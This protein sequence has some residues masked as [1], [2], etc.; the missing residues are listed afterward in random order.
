M[1]YPQKLFIQA[2]CVFC[3]I[4]ST[5]CPPLSDFWRFSANDR[6]SSSAVGSPV[7]SL[8]G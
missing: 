1:S 4:W 6:I 2:V 8:A 3:S 5:D 7:N